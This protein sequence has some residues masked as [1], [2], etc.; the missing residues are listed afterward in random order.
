MLRREDIL[1]AQDIVTESVP[2]PEWGGAVLVRSL[3]GTQREAMDRVIYDARQA[4]RPV[5]IFATVAAYSVVD[6][7]GARLFSDEDIATLATKS[8]APLER[9]WDWHQKHSGIGVKSLEDAI[10]NSGAGQNGATP[11]ASP[12]VS[13]A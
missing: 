3:S 6:I 9:I 13:A 11:S 1:A 2:V 4:G 10:K 5:S 7:H 12:S 8:S